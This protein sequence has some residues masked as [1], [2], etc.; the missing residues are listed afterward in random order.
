MLKKRIQQLSQNYFEEV[1]SIRRHL[2]QNPELSFQEVETGKFIAKTLDTFGVEHQTNVAGTGVVG[3]IQGENPD[4][5]VIA[6]RADID[7]LPIQEQ[8]KVAYKSKNEGVMH[9]CGHDVHTSSLLG[10]AKI[11]K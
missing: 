5:K 1:R 3:L 7:A 2:H 8:N 4:K 11:F 9:A 6:L 10:A